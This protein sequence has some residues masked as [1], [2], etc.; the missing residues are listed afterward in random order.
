MPGAISSDRGPH[1][2]AKVVQQIST[3]LGID[4]QLHTPYRP[5]SSGQVEK[6]N[7][8]IKIQIIKLSQEAGIPWLQVLPLALLRIRTKP[9]TKEGLSPYEILYG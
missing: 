3:L 9:S 8:L 2:I 1:F 5:Q 6:M 7:H 4:W